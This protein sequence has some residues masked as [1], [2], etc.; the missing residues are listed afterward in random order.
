LSGDRLHTSGVRRQATPEQGHALVGCN[1]QAH[2]CPSVD[3]GLIDRRIRLPFRQFLSFL[4]GRRQID[5]QLLFNLGSQLWLPASPAPSRQVR[6]D[7]AV[8]AGP[9]PEEGSR[10]CCVTGFR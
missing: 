6:N 1:K 5:R 8:D 3:K 4:V 10:S 7:Y 2:L 9:L